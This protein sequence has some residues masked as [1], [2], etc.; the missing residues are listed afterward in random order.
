MDLFWNVGEYGSFL[1]RPNAISCTL[2]D[3]LSFK[4]NKMS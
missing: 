3:L 2:G 4:G 1:E